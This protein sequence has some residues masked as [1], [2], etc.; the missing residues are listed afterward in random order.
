MGVVFSRLLHDLDIL[1]SGYRTKAISVDLHLLD[2]RCLTCLLHYSSP[3]L[4][5]FYNLMKTVEDHGCAIFA[6]IPS[7]CSLVP[8]CLDCMDSSR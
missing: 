4:P 1:T 5:R 7:A 8:I 6:R 3:E 2:T